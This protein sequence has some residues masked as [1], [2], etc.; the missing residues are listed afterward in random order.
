MSKKNL[1]NPRPLRR[2][3]F[4]DYTRSIWYAKGN[5]RELFTE[6]ELE[7]TKFIYSILEQ[8]QKEKKKKKKR[9]GMPTERK[10]T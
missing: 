5:Y 1:H 7:N 6:M 8:K 9:G 3:I 10:R 4:D 2:S